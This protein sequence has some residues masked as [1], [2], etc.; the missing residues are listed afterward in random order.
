MNVR[1]ISFST[2]INIYIYIFKIVISG[3]R[4]IIPIYKVRDLHK[5]IVQLEFLDIN[6]IQVFL[7][8]LS[9]VNK[10]IKFAFCFI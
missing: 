1:K 7:N 8:I 9:E 10:L 6:L 3:R 5:K 2:N 4:K